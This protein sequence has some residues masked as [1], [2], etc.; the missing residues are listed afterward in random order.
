MGSKTT[1]AVE[2][3]LRRIQ[4]NCLGSTLCQCQRYGARAAADIQYP[5]AV[6]HAS[7]FEE[8]FR[9]AGAPA[10]H[11][12]LIDIRI[13]RQER[14]QGAAHRN[15]PTDSSGSLTSSKATTDPSDEGLLL[16]LAWRRS[17]SSVI[18][19]SA[20]GRTLFSVLPSGAVR[21][22]AS[23]ATNVSSGALPGRLRSWPLG[24]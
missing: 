5:V 16:W 8:G 23:A 9:Q 2:V 22:P 15:H 7:E 6:L 20:S 12:V 18:G 17:A 10:T 11:E 14:R 24:R 19:S 3:R 1:R 21:L 4:P 13:C